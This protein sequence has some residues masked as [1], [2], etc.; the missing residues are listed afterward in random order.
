MNAQRD[1][2]AAARATGS[3]LRCCL[4]VL[5]ATLAASCATSVPPRE[6]AWRPQPASPEELRA[7]AAI[8][9]TGRAIHRMDQ[10]VWH[11]SDAL[12]VAFDHRPAPPG[13]NYAVTERDGVVRVSFLAE[14][15][16]RLRVLA[17]IDMSHSAPMVA[18]DPARE[19][20]D[21]ERRQ[22]RA[23]ATALAAAPDVC[24]GARNTVVLPVD[25]GA[26]DVYV[27]AASSD[28]AIVPLGGHAR[29]RVSADGAGVLAF[30]PYSKVCLDFDTNEKNPSGGRLRA[31][32]AS[33]VLSDLP[34]PTHVY[35]SLTYP[36]PIMLASR[37]HLWR[38]ADGHITDESRVKGVE[39]STP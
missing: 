23:R 34:A 30:E 26:M 12:L 21:G 19:P 18:L 5:L 33:I 4:G 14:E 27:L 1:C 10:F 38:V 36:W 7:I 20:D 15:N 35:T 13:S 22:M 17:D 37:T 28:P 25:G 32:M 6:S 39:P 24:E 16:G 31:L 2:T 29:V 9:A 11:A 3:I 8:T